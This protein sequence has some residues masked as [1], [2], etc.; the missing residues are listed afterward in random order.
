LFLRN[1]DITL[2]T[3]WIILDGKRSERSLGD[4]SGS[5][6]VY[7][8]ESS[9]PNYAFEK[10]IQTQRWLSLRDA[11][12]PSLEA[13]E[14]DYHYWVE[15]GDKCLPLV[16]AGFASSHREHSPRHLPF[17]QLITYDSI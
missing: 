9:L 1:I 8:H 6:E 11:M 3:W 5:Y 14:P 2:I 17:P 10:G 13:G 7:N 15:F 12:G 4:V 16:I